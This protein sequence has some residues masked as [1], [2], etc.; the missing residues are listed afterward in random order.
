MEKSLSIYLDLIRFIAACAV[1]MAHVPMFIGGYLWQ[2]GQWGHQ[3]VVVFFV[4]SGFV[5]AFVTDGK[6]KSLADYTINRVSRIYSVAIPAL[7]LSVIVF[8]WAM[9]V[10]PDVIAS[11]SHK[12]LNP[13]LTTAAA[14]T[15]TNQSWINFSI[16]AN[17]PYWSLGYE[18]LYYIFFG[19]I[20]FL[21]GWQR[22]LLAA[23]VILIMGPSIM[24]YMP[25]WWLG[26]LTYKKCKL[27]NSRS[28]SKSSNINIFLFICTVIL[29]FITALPFAV[30]SINEYITGLI[31]PPIFELLIP[32]AHKFPA[33]YLLAILVAINI[34][35]FNLVSEFFAKVCTKFENII[36]G[37]A[38]HTF[39]L[40]LFHFPVLCAFAVLVPFDTYPI[41]SLV[42]TIIL[43]PALVYLLGQITEDKRL[44]LRTYIKKMFSK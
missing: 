15:F 31:Y 16:F 43:S 12:M 30:K 27:I 18:V 17:P 40:Y 1:F 44:I 6:E 42:C 29:V 37:L 14:L 39:S 2:F 25:L 11:F 5:I 8:Y 21:S 22:V 10:K 41:T 34:Y 26:V 35:Y 9:A 7:V 33:D 20:F 38:K 23:L 13:Y 4:L 19:I 32:P 3:A 28:S 24:L 36:R